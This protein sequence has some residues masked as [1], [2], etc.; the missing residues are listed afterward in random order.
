MLTVWDILLNY[1]VI[2]EQLII[3]VFNLGFVYIILLKSYSN[4]LR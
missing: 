3:K 4:S 1:I 2:H